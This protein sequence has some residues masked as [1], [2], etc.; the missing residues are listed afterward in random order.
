MVADEAS[1]L[2]EVSASMKIK[3]GRP[4]VKS[5]MGLSARGFGNC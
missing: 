5:E 4:E 3:T 2:V 1:L